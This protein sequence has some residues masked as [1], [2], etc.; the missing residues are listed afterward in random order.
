MGIRPPWS[1]LFLARVHTAAGTAERVAPAA[2]AAAVARWLGGLG[3]ALDVVTSLDSPLRDGE[4]GLRVRQGRPTPEDRT[5]VVPALAGVAETG[6]VMVEATADRPG[7]LSFLPENH[8]V[9]VKRSDV[10]GS[11]DA[12]LQRL[13][14]GGM[15]SSAVFITGPS[16][17]GDIEQT[18][19]LGAHG[20]LRLHVLL[21]DDPA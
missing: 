3:V 4:A 7:L 14:A 16:R 8:I 18:L 2:V 19:Q 5:A 11:L 10:V 13:R 17:T 9:L 12:A 20:P 21:I 1:R 15:P 6:S